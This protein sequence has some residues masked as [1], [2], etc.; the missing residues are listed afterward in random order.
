MYRLQQPASVLGRKTGFVVV[1]F[2]GTGDVLEQTKTVDD[3]P[4]VGLI[5]AQIAAILVSERK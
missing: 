5:R 2:V 3:G 1:R 4:G